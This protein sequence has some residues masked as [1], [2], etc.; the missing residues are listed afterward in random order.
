M[1]PRDHRGRLICSLHGTVRVTTAVQ[2]K[3]WEQC[4]KKPY[5]GPII[6][7]ILAKRTV[8]PEFRRQDLVENANYRQRGMCCNFCLNVNAIRAHFTTA[9]P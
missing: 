1:L 4:H 2:I 5:H 7:I 3:E 9:C 6:A 8:S